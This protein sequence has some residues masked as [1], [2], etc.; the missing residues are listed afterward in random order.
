MGLDL[1]LDLL[2]LGSTA[3]C[4]PPVVDSGGFTGADVALDWLTF[5]NAR[6]GET[7]DP[8]AGIAVRAGAGDGRLSAACCVVN[9]H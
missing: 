7:P 5:E 8:R 4:A 3:A 2:P 9:P 1:D 6:E